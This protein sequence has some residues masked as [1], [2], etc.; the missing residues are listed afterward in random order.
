M[1]T[2]NS[3]V[4]TG[5]CPWIARKS[6]LIQKKIGGMAIETLLG[7]QEAHLYARHMVR[8]WR[9]GQEISPVL[10]IGPQKKQDTM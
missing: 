1:G 2:A 5:F 7:G 9:G 3:R 8:T 6:S 4:F 10:H